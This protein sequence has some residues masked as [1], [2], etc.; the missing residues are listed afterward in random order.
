MHI[1]LVPYLSNTEKNTGSIQKKTGSRKNGRNKPCPVSVPFPYFSVNTETVGS[2]VE[3]GTGRDRIF[4]G[5][6]STLSP[7]EQV[8]LDDIDEDEVPT[9]AMRIMA[10]GDVRPQEQLE[11]DQPSSS[12]M[13]HPPTHDDDQVLQDEGKDQGGA[14]EVQVMDEEAPQAPPTQVRATIQRNHP[15][16]QILGDI[17]K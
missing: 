3:N 15:V 5:P 16:D 12:T 17:S 2:N 13:V 4:F 8:D 9:T 1:R 6:F 10:I 7:R 14:Q 11:Q